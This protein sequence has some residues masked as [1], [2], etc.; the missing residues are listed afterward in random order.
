MDDIY[1]LDDDDDMLL[2]LQAF[3][4][5]VA[6]LRVLP[7]AIQADLNEFVERLAERNRCPFMLQEYAID[8]I[9]RRVDGEDVHLD[10]ERGAELVKI[11]N[12][13]NVLKTVGDDDALAQNCLAAVKESIQ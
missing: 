1:R 13:G 10:N 5:A 12:A 2:E 9:G 6:N 8:A 7:D 4:D 3:L 11:L